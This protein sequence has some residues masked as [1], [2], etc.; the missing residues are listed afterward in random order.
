MEQRFGGNR[1]AGGKISKLSGRHGPTM[2]A[3]PN[4]G[5]QAA[6][7]AHL[8]LELLYNGSTAKI[9][10][11]QEGYSSIRDTEDCAGHLGPAQ[12]PLVH[13]RQKKAKSDTINT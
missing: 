11:M 3:F 1:L 2:A 13:I 8:H 4:A 10:P 9:E 7:H 5:Q 6:R 12:F